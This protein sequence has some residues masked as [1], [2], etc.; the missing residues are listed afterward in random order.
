MAEE[1]SG[2]RAAKDPEAKL[3]ALYD[4][5]AAIV[6]VNGQG[7]ESKEAINTITLPT[8]VDTSKTL[9]WDPYVHVPYTIFYMYYIPC[10]VY[11]T[12]RVQGP[13]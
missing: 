8:L 13:K 10:T 4:A 3:D 5:S 2:T 7:F 11:H 9:S 6:A 1:G 12:L